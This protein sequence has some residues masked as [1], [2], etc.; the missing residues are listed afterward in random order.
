MHLVMDNFHLKPDQTVPCWLLPTLTNPLYTTNVPYL[1]DMSLYRGQ[2]YVYFG[3]I[4][5]VI[6]MIGK[7]ILPI[8]IG[9][10]YLVLVFISG[11]LLVE[12]L[13]ILKLWRRFFSDLPAGIVVCSILVIGSIS[14]FG[15]IFS[16]G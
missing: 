3:P 9:D 16:R 14:P 12:S 7:F 13:F 11:I 8:A 2:Y 4:P 10:Q 15:W 5:A 6:L 1:L